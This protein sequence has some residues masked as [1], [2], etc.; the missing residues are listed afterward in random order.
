M[1]E[2]DVELHIVVKVKQ[3]MTAAIRGTGDHVENLKLVAT[4]DAAAVQYLGRIFASNHSG[5]SP[6]AGP[7][8]GKIGTSL[9]RLM[10][11]LG[12]LAGVTPGRPYPEISF[13]WIRQPEWPA[14]PSGDV[15]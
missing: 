11:V 4:G 8:S 12:G 9:P 3:N 13:N 10:E 5:Y 6:Y 7:W 15:H 14:A 1:A 2:V